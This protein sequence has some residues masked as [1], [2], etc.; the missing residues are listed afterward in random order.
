M[1]RCIALVALALTLATPVGML[2]DGTGTGATSAVSATAPAAPQRHGQ[3]RL[4]LAA[5]AAVI[6]VF[7]L[8][9]KGRRGP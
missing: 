6:L 5:L 9:R 1:R 8:R 2:A 7:T 4:G 3:V